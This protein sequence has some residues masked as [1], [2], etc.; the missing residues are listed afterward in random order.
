MCI[1]CRDGEKHQGH[2][3]KPVKEAAAPLREKL[4]AYVQ[5]I[6]DDIT[7]TAKLANTQREEIATTKDKA[8]QLTTQISTQFKEMHQFL[9]KREDEI[10]NDLKH[11]EENALEEMTDTLN[12]METALTES[13]VLEGNVANVLEITDSERF[14]KSWTEKNSEVTLEHL[15]RPRANE[16][17]V[18]NASLSLGPY[19]SHLQFFMWKE[20]LQVV[21]PQAELLSLKSGTNNIT[22][23]DDGRNLMH[24]PKIIKAQCCSTLFGKQARLSVLW[25]QLQ[26]L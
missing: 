20:M 18:V 12:R 6:A 21:Q 11:K 1:I 8:Q 25:Q 14:V 19:E 4:E 10:K 2:K 3:F 22:V 7:A 23:S 9:L 5:V 16:L 13:R 24:R 15:F 17:Q 26:F